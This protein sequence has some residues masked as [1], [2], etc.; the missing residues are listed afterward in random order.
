MSAVLNWF[1]QLGS[2]DYVG[3][4]TTVA[5]IA[6]VAFVTYKLM[7]LVK[8]TRA[9]QI[10]WGLGVFFLFVII[11]E[12]LN[13]RALNWLLKV[14][15]PLGPVALVILFYPELRHALEQVGR[16]KFL[17]DG[18]VMLGREDITKLVEELTRVA[19]EASNSRTGVL[20]VVEREVGLDTTIRTGKEV[21]AEVSSE[22]LRTIFHP[23]SPLHDGAVI[24]RGDRIVAASCILPLS[25]SPR[26]GTMIHTRH[27]AAVGI[28]EQSDSIVLVVSEETGTISI[29][30][31]G[32][33]MRGLTPDQVKAKLLYLLQAGAG[34]DARSHLR[35]KVSSAL[36]RVWTGDSGVGHRT[37]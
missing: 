26:I 23:G 34:E 15:L 8:G 20:I 5:D 13:L 6:V 14:F 37:R 32:R 16:L 27:K 19:S 11:S 36:S 25:D 4:L 29:S 1:A 2:V 3:L 17:G 10:L 7:M 9:W 18:F 21:D 28:T 24:I 30:A 22:L 35:R 12:W 33:L 31:D